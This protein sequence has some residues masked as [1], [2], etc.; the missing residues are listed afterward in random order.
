MRIA[1]GSAGASCDFGA[2]FGGE[3]GKAGKGWLVEFK[4]NQKRWCCCLGT[5]VDL[6]MGRASLS[7]LP[8]A[9]V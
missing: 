8:A 1:G 9:G 7:F 3:A 4:V 2:L 6:G 5:R